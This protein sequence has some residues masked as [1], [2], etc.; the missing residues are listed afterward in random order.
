MCTFTGHKRSKTKRGM[1]E[2]YHKGIGRR[3]SEFCQTFFGT[4]GDEKIPLC[5]ES[6]C[7]GKGC[8]K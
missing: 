2:S 8:I 6:S 3:S 1:L 4:N 7:R 5:L